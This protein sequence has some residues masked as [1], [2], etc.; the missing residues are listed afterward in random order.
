M[1]MDVALWWLVSRLLY[2]LVPMFR[3]GMVLGWIT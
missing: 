1:V 2:M 3:S